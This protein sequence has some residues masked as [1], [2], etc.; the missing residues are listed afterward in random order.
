MT[1]TQVTFR[2]DHLE[3]FVTDLIAAYLGEIGFD[4]FEETARGIIGY[5]PFH[6]FSEQEMCGII[7]T[8]PI[9]G[10]DTITYRI[11]TISD[12]NWNAVWE[13][14][15]FHTIEITQDCII[16]PAL[17]QPKHPYRYDIVLQPT[18]SF[19]SGYH[20]TT[21]MMLQYLMELDIEN[22]TVLDMG[23]GTGVLAIMAA[24]RGANPV[25]AI[26]IDEWSFKNAKEN[27][28]LNNIDTV[29]TLLGDATLLDAS[30]KSHYDLVLANINRNILLA[31]IPTYVAAMRPGATLLVSGFYSEDLEQIKNLASSLGLH[32]ID[33]K[34]DN[35]WIAAR[36]SE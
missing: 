13:Q 1:Y 6:L 19:G 22:K 7:T 29:N 12:Q 10:A 18:Q 31:D 9:E 34:T 28:T 3:S 20:E 4:S 2:T 33:Y 16:R 27:F 35:N 36:F 14:N 5:C 24:M 15:S 21:R 30:H 32:L 26:D 25:T 17:E 8:L 23:T 11:S